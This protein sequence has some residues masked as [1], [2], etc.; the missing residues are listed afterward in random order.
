MLPADELRRWN[1][2]LGGSGHLGAAD[3][4]YSP[5]SFAGVSDRSLTVGVGSVLPTSRSPPSRTSSM[6]SSPVPAWAP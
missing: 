5:Y 1:S 3:S 4:P 2:A 6:P